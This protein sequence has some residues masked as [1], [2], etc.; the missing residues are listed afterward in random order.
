MDFT[1]FDMFCWGQVCFAVGGDHNSQTFSFSIF[2]SCLYRCLCHEFPCFPISWW[3]I[4]FLAY[5]DIFQS[6]KDWRK[7]NCLE[8]RGSVLFSGTET[9]LATL[10]T[11]CYIQK[12]IF[13]THTS[14]VHSTMTFYLTEQNKVS[15]F[16]CFTFP[17]E[18]HVLQ[19]K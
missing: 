16:T 5:I 1:H 3:H 19:F 12:L 2:F 11:K 7:T 18:F 6:R 14:S 17:E 9:V 10:K 15:Y 4:Q 13:T 8:P